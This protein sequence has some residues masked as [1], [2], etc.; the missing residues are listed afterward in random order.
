MVF[1]T[2]LPKFRLPPVSAA[3]TSPRPVAAGLCAAELGRSQSTGEVAVRS[4]SSRASR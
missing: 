3:H 4:P 1:G 2:T